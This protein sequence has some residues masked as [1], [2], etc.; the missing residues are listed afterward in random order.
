MIQ[1]FKNDP[2]HV[3]YLMSDFNASLGIA[4]VNKLRKSIET[5]RKIG[6]FYDEAV[7]GSGSTLIGRDDGKELAYSSYALKT[8]TPF[9]ECQ[10][11][12][13][14]YGIPVQRGLERP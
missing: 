3:E 13:K 6:Q 4:Q 12:F 7:L 5:R 1:S 9:E 8:S 11:F 14:R 10:R 2:A